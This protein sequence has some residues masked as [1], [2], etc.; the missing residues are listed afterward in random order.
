MEKKIID[1]KVLFSIVISIFSLGSCNN[2]LDLD[3]FM[4]NR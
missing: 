2:L 3:D 1:F 4:H